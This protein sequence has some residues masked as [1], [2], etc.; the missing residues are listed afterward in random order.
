M[1]APAPKEFMGSPRRA[2]SF[3]LKPSAKSSIRRSVKMALTNSALV[4]IE[5]NSIVTSIGKD[6]IDSVVVNAELKTFV[7]SACKV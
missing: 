3:A 5:V 7:I 6:K 1:I 2:T 4:E